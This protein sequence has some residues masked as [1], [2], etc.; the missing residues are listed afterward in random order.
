MTRHPLAGLLPVLPNPDDETGLLYVGGRISEDAILAA[1]AMGLFPWTGAHPIPWCSPDPR[2]LLVPETIPVRRSL[3]KRI[4]HGGF[5]VQLDTNLPQVMAFCRDVPRPRQGGT[6]ITPNLEAAWTGL[7]QR[8]FAHSVEV[9]KDGELVGGLYGLLLGNA[10]FGESMFHTTRDASK[11]A[12]VALCRTVAQD[13]VAFID[14]QAMTPHLASMG[15]TALSRG[16]YLQ[17]LSTA[18]S[19]ERAPAS[20]ADRA[21]PDLL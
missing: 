21:V 7:W 15:A 4:R 19:H 8:G 1:Y 16:S 5:A 18:L 12:L 13:G 2:A 17:R 20:W 10:F 3:A 11:V 9:L 14:C 6:W